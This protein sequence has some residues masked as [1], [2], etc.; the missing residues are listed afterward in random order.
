MKRFLCFLTLLVS[1]LFFVGIGIAGD[2][3]VNGYFKSNGTYVEPHY[4]SAPDGN[5]QNNWSTKG[6]VN[7]YT[8]QQGTQVTPPSGYRYGSGSMNS[9]GGFTS[10]S[11]LGGSSQ[12]SGFGWDSNSSQGRRSRSLSDE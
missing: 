6:N 11:G 3:Y 5:F 7:P 12:G 10:G 9:L 8:G 4:R 1:L 2:T